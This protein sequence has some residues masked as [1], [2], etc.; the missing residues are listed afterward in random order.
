MANFSYGVGSSSGDVTPI[1]QSFVNITELTVN[2]GLSYMPAVWVVDSSN[3]LILVS[4]SYGSGSI[5]IYSISQIT[6][7]VY[8]R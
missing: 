5:T 7:T 8:I 3:N 6:G 1:S 2:H 4:V